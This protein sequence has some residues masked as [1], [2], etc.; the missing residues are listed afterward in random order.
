MFMKKTHDTHSGYPIYNT[1]IPAL[2]TMGWEY[3]IDNPRVIRYDNFRKEQ[4]RIAQAMGKEFTFCC[5]GGHGGTLGIEVRSPVAPLFQ[6]KQWA[7]QLLPFTKETI[8]H[9]GE[10][11]N[12]GIHVNISKN[13]FTNKQWNKVRNFL[14]NRKY[15]DTLHKL[16][17]RSLARFNQNAP[18]G[19]HTTKY[20]I[21]TASKSYAY[22]LRMFGA[23]TDTFLPAL[24]FADALFRHAASVDEIT[25][26]K[27]FSFIDR[28]PKYEIL[29]NY[30]A[31]KLG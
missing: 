10:H 2:V 23:H 3:E 17:D 12:G 28:S 30:I 27:F 25:P 4:E 8:H 24:E 13:E 7:T 11:N 31:Q 18:Q 22:E 16:S 15:Y 19:Y 21:I 26:D 9:N 5:D 20:G 6:V 1:P 14:H 29:S